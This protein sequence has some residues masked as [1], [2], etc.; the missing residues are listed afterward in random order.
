MK[1]RLRK[2]RDLG[3]YRLEQTNSQALMLKMYEMG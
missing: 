2:G 3:Y 1:C